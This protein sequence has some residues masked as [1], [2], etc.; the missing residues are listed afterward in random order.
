MI[1]GFQPTLDATLEIDL[2]YRPQGSGGQRLATATVSDA[3]QGVDGGFPGD[4]NLVLTA[5]P[6]MPSCGDTLVVRI[7]FAQ[8]SSP[9]S[10]LDVMLITP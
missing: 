1:R 6:V 2:L 3:A 7:K 10:D 9:Y 5:P 4:I 8:G